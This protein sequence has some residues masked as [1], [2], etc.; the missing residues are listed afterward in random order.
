MM[1]INSRLQD[2]KRLGPKP[3]SRSIIVCTSQ[4]FER[5]KRIPCRLWRLKC[6]CSL[7]ISS[8]PFQVLT[9]ITPALKSQGFKIPT[10]RETWIKTSKHLTMCQHLSHSMPFSLTESASISL[11]CSY[12]CTRQHRVDDQVCQRLEP[13][14]DCLKKRRRCHISVLCTV[15]ESYDFFPLSCAEF[16][17]SYPFRKSD[18]HML[19]ELK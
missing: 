9:G 6:R 5:L 18:K 12:G 2:K 4:P 14:F 8:L 16:R 15:T 7:Q 19:P 1:K 11:I 10:I 3:K 17:S 13:G